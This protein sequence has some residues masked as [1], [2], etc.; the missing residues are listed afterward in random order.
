M[1]CTHLVVHQGN[2]RRYHHGHTMTSA[3]THDGRHLVAQAFAAACGHQHQRITAAYNVIDD[4]GL[5]A[6]K[7]VKTKDLVQHI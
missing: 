1:Q 7:G 5:W 3:L 6:S 2:Q 4:V